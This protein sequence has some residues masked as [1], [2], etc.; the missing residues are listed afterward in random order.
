MERRYHRS[1]DERSNL[2]ANRFRT[3]PLFEIGPVVTVFQR[4]GRFYMLV[5]GEDKPVW[6]TRLN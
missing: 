1:S 6:V 5:D 2:A 3:L 4:G